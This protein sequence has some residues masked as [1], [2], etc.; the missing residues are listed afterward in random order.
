[1]L[2]P[3]IEKRHLEFIKEESEPFHLTYLQTDEQL[4]L[5]QSLIKS[6]LAIWGSWCTDDK[7]Y[8]HLTDIGRHV[9]TMAKE[10]HEC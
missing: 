7:K 5:A 2:F 9:A 6:G 3:S 8:V 1:M 4:S 10:Q